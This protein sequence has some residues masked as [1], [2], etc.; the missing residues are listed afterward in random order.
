M[1]SI[2]H[3]AFSEL[4]QFQPGLCV[5]YWLA[6]WR[7]SHDI[8]NIPMSGWS[9]LPSFWAGDYWCWS[10]RVSWWN[11]RCDREDVQAPLSSHSLGSGGWREW[12][13]QSEL[14]R[15]RLC[16]S[17]LHAVTLQPSRFCILA[18]T[19]TSHQQGQ[20][21]HSWHPLIRIS[22]PFSGPLCPGR[23]E[24]TRTIIL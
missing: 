21:T 10:V 18:Q 16:C 3:L 13:W 17:I 12:V 4:G 23:E 9:S 2:F 6:A 14:P 1:R 7:G 19:P 8:I 22:V 5:Q 11:C 15:A 24:K 20:L